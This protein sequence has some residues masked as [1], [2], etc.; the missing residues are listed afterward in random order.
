MEK[1]RYVVE[2]IYTIGHYVHDDCEFSVCYSLTE[3][4]AL[5][6]ALNQGA[7]ETYHFEWDDFE[8]VDRT[9]GEYVVV[10]R[11]GEN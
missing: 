5:A 11:L 1:L 3:A 4:C 8:S 10:H 9:V 7:I 2:N 6:A